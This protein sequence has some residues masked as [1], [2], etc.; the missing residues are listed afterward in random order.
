MKRVLLTAVAVYATAL[1]SAAAVAQPAKV[2]PRA[3]FIA[4]NVNNFA[5]VDDHSVYVRV[6]VRDVYHLTMFGTCP[7]LSWAH[8]LSLA[9]R[10]GSW[11]CEGGHADVDVV[12][13]GGG[14]GP[15]RCRV[16]DVRKLTPEAV[17]AL[18]ERARP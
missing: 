6:G 17:L 9:S 2:S 18:P 10:S 4:R 14:T 13:R 12:T 5:A 1:T 8:A 11:I 3:C 7:D 16:S 15:N